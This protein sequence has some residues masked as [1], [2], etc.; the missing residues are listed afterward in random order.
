MGGTLNLLSSAPCGG[1]TSKGGDNIIKL[2]KSSRS[3]FVV[4]IL[5]SDKP[6]QYPDH[7]CIAEQRLAR[8]SGYWYGVHDTKR[9]L[10]IPITEVDALLDAIHKVKAEHIYGKEGT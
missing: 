2:P 3:K 10:F 1:R 4:D 5:P 6:L 8:K 9:R 7:I